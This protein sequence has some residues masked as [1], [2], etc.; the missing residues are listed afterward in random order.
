MMARELVKRATV[1]RA[2]DKCARLI[3]WTVVRPN[4]RALLSSRQTRAD[5]LQLRV[6]FVSR[7]CFRI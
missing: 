6:P 5:T 3:N 4:W 7:R 2:K 1:G